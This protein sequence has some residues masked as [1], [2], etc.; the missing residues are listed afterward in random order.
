MEEIKE[1]ADEE[2]LK[3]WD[4]GSPLYDSY[5][6]VAVSNV[7]ERHCLALPYL[8]GSREVV[9]QSCPSPRLV[10]SS[11]VKPAPNEAL[12]R[13]A[14]KSSVFWLF[15]RFVE[16]TLWKTKMDPK[17]RQ[18]GKKHN[19]EIFKVFQCVKSSCKE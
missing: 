13:N 14:R 18:R 1:A 5:E 4:C 10:S 8:N 7:I 6:L 19:I 17:T 16:G 2:V 12:S 3:I 9:T 15:S 11:V